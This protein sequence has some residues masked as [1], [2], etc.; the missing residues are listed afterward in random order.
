MARGACARSRVPPDPKSVLAV[1]GG[2][3]EKGRGHSGRRGVGERS[4]SAGVLCTSEGAGRVVYDGAPRVRHGA[5][6]GP[7]AVDD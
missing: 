7:V 5:G 6:E 2:F 1:R 3:G 4:R